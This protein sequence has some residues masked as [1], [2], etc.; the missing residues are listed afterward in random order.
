MWPWCLDRSCHFFESLAAL[1]TPL[2]SKEVRHGASTLSRMQ[3]ALHAA[4]MQPPERRKVSWLFACLNFP[5]T[6]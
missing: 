1:V 2:V 3:L 5:C 4:P 6:W